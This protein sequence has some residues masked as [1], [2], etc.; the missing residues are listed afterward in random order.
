MV[1]TVVRELLVGEGLRFHFDYVLNPV[2][3]DRKGN[4]N[5]RN[6]KEILGDLAPP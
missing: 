3:A 4:A 5:F 6:F 2:A 1:A